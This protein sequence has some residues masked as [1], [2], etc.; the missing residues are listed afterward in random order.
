MASSFQGTFITSFQ[1]T[2]IT[3]FQGTFITSFQGT[4]R[5]G[6]AHN[7]SCI[8]T[9]PFWH[10]PPHLRSP[11]II[12]MHFALISRNKVAMVQAAMQLQIPLM[13]ATTREDLQLW[14][15]MFVTV[16]LQK[17]TPH[18]TWTQLLGWMDTL[19]CSW[20]DTTDFYDTEN[21]D[22]YPGVKREPLLC[23]VAAREGIVGTIQAIKQP[24]VRAH[25]IRIV[26]ACA[27]LL[28]RVR[29]AGP[30]RSMDPLDKHS[31]VLPRSR[32]GALVTDLPIVDGAVFEG[33]PM[34]KALWDHTHLFGHNW[35]MVV[36]ETTFATNLVKAAAGVP[37]GE[38]AA[39]VQAVEA[40]EP[41]AVAAMKVQEAMAAANKKILEEQRAAWAEHTRSTE[42]GA[43]GVEKT[44]MGQAKQKT[45]AVSDDETV[46]V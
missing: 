45:S 43:A 22:F 2:F 10:N 31:G 30:C 5:I 1:G 18:T 25:V 29:W 33:R 41:V 37:V 16:A 14:G 26:T 28:H 40:A 19:R 20:G 12:I 46:M 32:L 23:A 11:I 35:E 24:L 13:V 44:R 42:G 6:L 15:F 39:V 3:S 7:Q 4:K 8:V 9:F 21:D 36:L 34:D 17:W 38:L 27:H